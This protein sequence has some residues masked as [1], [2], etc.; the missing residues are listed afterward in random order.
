[1][2]STIDNDE[3]NEQM[4]N[5]LKG[6]YSTLKSQDKNIRFALL[7][8]VTRFSKLSVFSDL[9]NLKDIS[10]LKPYEAICGITEQEL[11][12]NFDDDVQRLA[13]A[14]GLTKEQAYQRLQD[15]YDGYHFVANGV[16]IYNPF[17]LFNVLSDSVFDDYWFET[18]TPTFLVKMLQKN[19]Y[20]LTEFDKDINV[21]R[22]QLK[23]IDFKQNAVPAMYQSGYLTIK[24]YNPKRDRYRLGFPNGEVRRGFN[25]YLVQMSMTQYNDIERDN[26]SDRLYDAADAG[27]VET[28]MTIFKQV[29]G[30]T[31]MHSNDA[32]KLEVHYR[33]TIYLMLVMCGHKPRVEQPTAAGRIDVS[34][35]TDNYV[36]VMELKRGDTDEAIEQIED[37][38]Y[39]DAYAA[40]SRKVIAIAVAIN[41]NTR[42]IGNWRVVN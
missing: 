19:N 8:G 1:L 38:R 35:E 3:L 28:M 34:L 25:D 37:R 42:N 40:D 12:D 33:N 17:S 7:T 26:L 6:F 2:L 31:P 13:E 41:D 10:M 24:D 30:T 36:Y 39:L 14:N 22:S 16:G 9:N 20:D 21:G 11:H 29:M 15:E 18:G 27:D 32:S 23:N 4:R 5:V